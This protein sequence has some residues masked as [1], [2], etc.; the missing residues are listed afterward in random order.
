M[1]YWLCFGL[2]DVGLG[3]SA[4]GNATLLRAARHVHRREDR[5]SPPGVF[6]VQV[7]P[8]YVKLYGEEA[9][10]VPSGRTASSEQLPGVLAEAG[11]DASR[12]AGELRARD[13][14]GSGTL[15]VVALKAS[16]ASLNAGACPTHL[17]P[18][19]HILES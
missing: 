13:A 8:L 1:S 10:Y 5:G 12:L 6:L 3:G 4:D 15:D 18:H 19:G 9:E 7:R 16:L 2:L 14:A 11:V 17:Q